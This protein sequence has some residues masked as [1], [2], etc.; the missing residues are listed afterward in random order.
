MCPRASGIVCVCEREGLSECGVD[1]LRL[2]G[3][4]EGWAHRG[5][6]LVGCRRVVAASWT[7]PL[8]PRGLW[9]GGQVPCGVRVGEQ[10]GP[11]DAVWGQRVR[12]GG[13]WVGKVSVGNK[14]ITILGETLFKL[15]FYGS[16]TPP[17][18]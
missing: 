16:S 14:N 11:H 9:L 1:G 4:T 12:V 2:G 15:R 8:R 6:L 7:A 5:G 10:V 3:L 13:S 17:N 18:I